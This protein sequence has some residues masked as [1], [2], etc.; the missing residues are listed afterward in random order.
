MRVES[1][2]RPPTLLTIAS[3][4]SS[5]NMRSPPPVPENNRPQLGNR[6]VQVVVDDL[7]VVLPRVG[8]FLPGRLQP[9]PDRVLGLGAALPQPP[10]VLVPGGGEQEDRHVVGTAA[11]HL[12]RPL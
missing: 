9:P 2:N 12:G 8:Q 5:S 6:L 4:F 11:A 3:S 1:L 10:L 7:V